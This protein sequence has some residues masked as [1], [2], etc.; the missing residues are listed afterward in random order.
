MIQVQSL[1]P[2]RIQDRESIHHLLGRCP[3]ARECW[4]LT[5]F[6]IQGR[7]ETIMSWFSRLTLA[8]SQ[9][10]VALTVM[11]CWFYGQI[12]IIRCGGTKVGGL[13]TSSI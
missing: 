13:D 9:E 4:L 5:P 1:C 6:P 12:A 10:I 8:C 11:I 7:F 3:I 2:V